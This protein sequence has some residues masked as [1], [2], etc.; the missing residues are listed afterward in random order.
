MEQ[1]RE[2]GKCKEGTAH[3]KERQCMEQSRN[4]EIHQE[5][6]LNAH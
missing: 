1:E 5:I 6:P 4:R 3:N 2:L